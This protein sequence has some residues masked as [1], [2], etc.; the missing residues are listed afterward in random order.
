ML[1]R[2]FVEFGTAVPNSGLKFETLIVALN[3]DPLHRLPLT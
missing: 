2:Q 1:L 3:D